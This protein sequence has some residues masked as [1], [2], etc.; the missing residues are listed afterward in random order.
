MKKFIYPLLA[1]G[2]IFFMAGEVQ[3]QFE[4][5]VLFE[6]YQVDSKGDRNKQDR[7]TMFVTP[8]RIMFQGDEQYNFIGNIK[9]E[10]VLVR[11]DFEDFVFLT[12]QDEAL[13]ISRQ[14]IISMMNMFGNDEQP[15]S[16]PDVNYQK[17]SETQQVRGYN[18]EKFIFTDKDN[19]DHHSVVWMTKDLN[20][21][22]GMLS[23]SW[24]DSKS[25]LG[26]DIPLNLVFEEGYF[27][28]KV[29]TFEKGKLSGVMEAT[30]VMES[31]IARA[32]VQIP[33]GVKV[34]SFQDYLFQKMSQQ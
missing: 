30:E 7:F 13:K 16:P 14:D 24:G 27:P 10:G 20:I 2:I 1:A 12:G 22:W 4:G 28:L 31:S 34:L 6:S 9:T 26:G 25:S 8:E 29:E 23:D 15:A 33:S 32:M 18:C 19:S 11:L 5:K 17:T 21:Y 3:A